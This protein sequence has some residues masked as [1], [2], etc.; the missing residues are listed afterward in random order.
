VETISPN[1]T[2]KGNGRCL[3]DSVGGIL[4]GNSGPRDSSPSSLAS[5][6]K[7]QLRPQLLL[8]KVMMENHFPNSN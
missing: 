6:M 7:F 5:S 2:N 8:E 4:G 3:L 1:L